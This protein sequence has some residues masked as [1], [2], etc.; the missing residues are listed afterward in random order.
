MIHTRSAS[1]RRGSSAPSSSSTASCGTVRQQFVGDESVAGGVAVVHHVPHGQ[2]VGAHLI[3]QRDEQASGLPGEAGGEGD[4]GL[5]EGRRTP[6]GGRVGGPSRRSVCRLWP[7]TPSY[8][9]MCSMKIEAAADATILH[10]DLDSFYASVEQR[11]DPRLRN[12]PVIVGGGIVLAASY[13]AKRRGVYTPMLEHKARRLCP[14][15]VVVPPRFEAYTEASKAVFDVFHDTTPI[16]E[17]LSI[18]EAFLDVSGLRRIAGRTDRHR[19]PAA[20]PSAR[21]ASACRSPSAWPVRSSW[22][23][24]RAV[25]PSPTGCSWSSPT[26]N[27]SSCTRCRSATLGRRSDHRA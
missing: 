26:A 13:E 20:R 12:R 18:D 21:A 9:N 6:V 7:R 14:D 23:R 11:D 1:K 15:L 25:S 4:V 16:V 10:A 24:W 5:G 2:A 27:S 19:P 22:P 17:G 3:A 8:A